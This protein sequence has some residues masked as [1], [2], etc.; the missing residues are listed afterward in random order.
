MATLETREM[1]T[2]TTTP[3]NGSARQSIATFGRYQEAQQ[4][5]DFLSDRGFPMQHVAIVAEGLK[6]VEQITGRLSW[7]KAALNGALSGAMVGALFGFIF[8]LFSWID[9]LISTL[10]L[11]L[12]G[13]V[14][15]AIIGLI[16]GLITYGLSGGNRDFTS[17]GGIQ[18]DRY[19]V[20]VESE[21]ANEAQRLIAE[22][23]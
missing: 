12:Y 15:G 10:T 14:F 1:S 20:M 3:T 4:A 6:F 2:L 16:M 7:G 8:G 21:H 22:M 18:A 17:V 5:V 13:L 11:T 19:N 9:P 23:T